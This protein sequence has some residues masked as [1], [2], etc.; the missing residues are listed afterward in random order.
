[1][2]PLIVVARMHKCKN[3]CV[4]KFMYETPD[5]LVS[6]VVSFGMFC[7]LF[8]QAAERVHVGAPR[9]DGLGLYDL[10]GGGRWCPK[11]SGS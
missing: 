10:R 1:M 9:F 5:W 6:P 3:V 2:R 7:H 8:S 4:N 11:A